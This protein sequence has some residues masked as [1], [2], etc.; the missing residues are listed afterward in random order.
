MKSLH[1]HGI[2]V[3]RIITNLLISYKRG[4]SW[5]W[6]K[7]KKRGVSIAVIIARLQIGANSV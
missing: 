1:D 3:N 5:K 6:K 2:I 4:A 7:K